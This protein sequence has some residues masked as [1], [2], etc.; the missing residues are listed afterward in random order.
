MAFTGSD[1]LA[2]SRAGTL[3]KI[4]GS[5][6]LAYVQANVGTSEFEV[7]DITARNALSNM[8][9]GDRIFVADASSDA[10][11]T[12]G[13][14]IYVYRSPGVYT[15]V[16]EEESLDI[17]VGGAN[18]T[19][20][21]GASSGIVVSSSGTDATLPAVTDSEAGLSLPAHKIKLD[22]VTVTAATNLDT[23]RTAS[24]AAVT[25]AGTAA[26]NPISVS[27]QVLSFNIASLT[28]AP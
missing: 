21:P 25:T 9:I 16:A 17:T 18:L 28:T 13:W 7:A 10:N 23:L 6:I 20:T 1:N 12:S 24:H 4:S 22:Y 8:S 11:V 26:S 19:Y 2:I 15:R 27:G 5:D 3:Y 14:A